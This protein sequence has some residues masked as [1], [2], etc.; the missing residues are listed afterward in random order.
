MPVGIFIFFREEIRYTA[1]ARVSEASV[2]LKK[3]RSHKI[4]HDSFW[5]AAQEVKNIT[6]LPRK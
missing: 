4:F 6:P 2:P 3:V 1:S 5:K